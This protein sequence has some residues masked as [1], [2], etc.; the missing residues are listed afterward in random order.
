MPRRFRTAILPIAVFA[1]GLPALGQFGGGGGGMG[2]GI[3]LG[4]GGHKSSEDERPTAKKDPTLRPVRGIVTDA[5]GKPVTGA[6]VELKDTRTQKVLSALTHE[7]GDYTFSG[8][9]KADDY[10]LKATFEEHSSEAHTL[11]SYDMREQPVVNLQLK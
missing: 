3:P 1:L 8:L 11:S 2:D 9:K 5:D 6:V 7:K 4:G 10:E